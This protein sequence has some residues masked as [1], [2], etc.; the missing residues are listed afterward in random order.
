MSTSA[1]DARSGPDNNDGQQKDQ[2]D[3][4]LEKEKEEFGGVKIG[5]AFF[6]WLTATGT[7]ILLTALATALGA[8]VG[9]VTNTDVADQATQDPQTA[10]IVGAIILAVVLFI[11]YYCGGYVAGR[12]ARF[13]GMK[14]GVAVWAWA[15]VIAIVVGILG[16]IAG[17][18]FNLLAQV[19]SFPQ[20]P[21]ADNMTTAGIIS[22]I[23]AAVIALVGAILGGL[24][25]MHFHRKVDKANLV[26]NH[27]DGR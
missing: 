11:S 20:I 19:N 17:D 24:A 25:G 16:L 7:A 8:V 21:N 22:A 4:L 15:I 3:H 10:G 9:N 1:G 18:Q 27:V 26:D 23:V 14:Q 13:N 12:M 6:G 5:S 2:R